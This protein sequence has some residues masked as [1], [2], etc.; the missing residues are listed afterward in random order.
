MCGVLF[1]FSG[2]IG[3]KARDDSREKKNEADVNIGNSFVYVFARINKHCRGLNLLS[4]R[5]EIKIN[6]LRPLEN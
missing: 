6:Y 2:I 4:G 5:V 3:A 1:E